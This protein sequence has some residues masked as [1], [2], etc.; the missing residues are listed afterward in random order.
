MKTII[1]LISMLFL[2]LIYA[3]TPTSN[4]KADLM[5]M[6]CKHYIYLSEN[7]VTLPNK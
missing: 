1:T 7:G 3:Q 4:I 5:K 6:D 2:T